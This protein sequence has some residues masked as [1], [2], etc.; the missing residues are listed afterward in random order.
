MR[1]SR[2]L[3][4][5][6]YAHNAIGSETADANDLLDSASSPS[7]ERSRHATRLAIFMLTYLKRFKSKKALTG[8]ERVAELPV[9]NRFF[10]ITAADR[11]LQQRRRRPPQRHGR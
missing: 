5:Q 9:Y 7:S 6:G 8:G 2:M 3:S 4:W 1:R 10:N 11:A